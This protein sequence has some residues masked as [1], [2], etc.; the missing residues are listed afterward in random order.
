M[1]LNLL[2]LLLTLHLLHSTLSL[3]PPPPP[4]PPPPQRPPQHMWSDFTLNHTIPIVGWYFDSTVG[5]GVT[6]ARVYDDEELSKLYTMAI[7]KVPQIHVYPETDQWMFETLKKYS[8]AGKRVLVVG[9]QVPWYEMLCFAY[10]AKEVVVVE[11]QYIRYEGERFQNKLSYVTPSE[12]WSS[13]RDVDDDD[14][15]DSRDKT[16]T[17][18]TGVDL[19]DVIIS[20]SSEEHNGLGRYGDQLNP[21]ADVEHMDALATIGAIIFLAMPTSDVDCLVFN[22]HRIYGPVR[23]KLLSRSWEE[24]DLIGDVGRVVPS[25]VGD[26]I[27]EAHTYQ[28][29]HVLRSKL[30]VSV[31]T[32]EKVESGSE[33]SGSEES[34]GE[35]LGSIEDYCPHNQILSGALQKYAARTRSQY[36]KSSDDDNDDD[37]EWLVFTCNCVDEHQCRSKFSDDQMKGTGTDQRPGC[38]CGGLGDRL[39]GI[40]SSFVVALL[41]GRLFVIDWQTPC[42]LEEHL[43]PHAVDWATKLWKSSIKKD[44][45]AVGCTSLFDYP[46]KQEDFDHLNLTKIMRNHKIVRWSTNV[47]LLPALF[48]SKIH[49]TQMHEIFGGAKNRPL[50]TKHFGCLFSFLFQ[51]SPIMESSVMRAHHFWTTREGRKK[52]KRKRLSVQIRLGGIW[53]LDLMEVPS[54]LTEWENEVRERIVKEDQTEELTE[55]DIF[56][57]SDQ[58][59]A[60]PFFKKQFKQD[61]PRIQ[62]YEITSMFSVHLDHVDTAVPVAARPS[63]GSNEMLVASDTQNCDSSISKMF[64][65]WW[66]LGSSDVIFCSMSG[67]GASAIWRTMH[68]DSWILHSWNSSGG[69]SKAKRY[70]YYTDWQLRESEGDDG[71]RVRREVPEEHGSNVPY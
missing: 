27:T 38:Q 2:L 1:H 46:P 62:V 24:V 65:D 4:P 34:D 54:N 21:W 29:V 71:R 17:L 30:W 35:M 61:A 25:C 57:T 52:R 45:A 48:L 63:T 66:I 36:I 60:Y 49:G 39:N 16:M 40:M 51:L 10:G 26:S 14:D 64:L 33:E 59:T 42:P 18:R 31:E 8:V 23:W 3:P 69:D 41:T 19:F 67:F 32:G 53:D 47:N 58:A 15:D 28:P 56:V 13:Q 7:N 68:N 5:S 43:V 20:I 50:F 11:Y 37:K 6:T 44:A 9:S 12:L 55:W 70:L 22:A